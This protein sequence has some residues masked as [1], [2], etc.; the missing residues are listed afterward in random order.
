MA[1]ITVK[2]KTV[3]TRLL[4]AN[5]KRIGFMII[6]DSSVDVY[7]GFDKGVATSGPKKGVP[8]KANGGFWAYEWHKGEVWAIAS[9]ETEVTVVESSEG[10]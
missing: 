1:V 9:T 3:P 7:V 10:E 6:N 5:P 8:I 4:V 2:V